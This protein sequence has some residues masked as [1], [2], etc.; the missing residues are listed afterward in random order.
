MILEEACRTESDLIVSALVA[1]AS[2]GRGIAHLQS[3]DPNLF[4]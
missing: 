2:D 3:M 4:L 1:S